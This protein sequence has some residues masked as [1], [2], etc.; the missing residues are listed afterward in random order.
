[1]ELID[2]CIFGFF[3]F[4]IWMLQIKNIYYVELIKR[5]EKVLAFITMSC[6][7][8]VDLSDSLL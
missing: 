6:V 4:T 5:R 8:F 1:M 2:L 3:F 7:W